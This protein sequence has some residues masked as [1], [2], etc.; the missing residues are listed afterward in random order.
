MNPRPSGLDY[1][2]SNQKVAGKV[3][4]SAILPLSKAVNP[5]QQLLLD[6][7]DRDVD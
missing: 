5:Q 7:D 1:W 4:K 3:D 2:S 6:T